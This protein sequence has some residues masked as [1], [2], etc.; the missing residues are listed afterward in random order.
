MRKIIHVT[1]HIYSEIIE[2]R[3]SK[4]WIK[5]H[6]AQCLPKLLELVSYNFEFIIMIFIT[7]QVLVIDDRNICWRRSANLPV[8]VWK[9]AVLCF[10]KLLAKKL[11]INSQY[12]KQSTAEFYF[13]LSFTVSCFLQVLFSLHPLSRF[14]S[15]RYLLSDGYRK[16]LILGKS[17][18]SMK[19]IICFHIRLCMVLH[20]P[21]VTLQIEIFYYAQG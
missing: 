16:G 7:L 4:M 10:K 3:C 21:L 20:L 12:P 2:H 6:R 19:P 18:Q 9:V 8:S 5:K 11:K 15:A 13:A 14:W 1:Y 17:G